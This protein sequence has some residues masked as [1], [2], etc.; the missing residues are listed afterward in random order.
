MHDFTLHIYCSRLYRGSR[1][2]IIWFLSIYWMTYLFRY[3]FC[4]IIWWCNLVILFGVKGIYMSRP[5]LN[6][7]KGTRVYTPSKNILLIIMDIRF[8]LTADIFVGLNPF[9][10]EPFGILVRK[11]TRTSTRNCPRV[12]PTCPGVYRSCPEIAK[13]CFKLDRN[14]LGSNCLGSNCP[15]SKLSQNQVMCDS[16]VKAVP[17]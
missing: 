1:I 10:H 5:I 12:D 7:R 14:C 13:A 6:L 9:G 15:G 11:L 2:R 3:W 8:S 4:V 17:G 16:P